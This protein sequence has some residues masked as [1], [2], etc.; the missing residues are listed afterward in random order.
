ML[1]R[2]QR[3]FYGM[4][5]FGSQVLLSFIDL[6]AFWIYIDRFGLN[7][8]FSAIGFSIGKLVIAI[9]GPL[10]G[11]FSDIIWT[12]RW[13]RRKIFFIFGAPGLAIS[14]AL[15]FVPNWFISPGNQLGLLFYMMGAMAIF[16]FFYALLMTPY[17]A[18]M[19]EITEPE[20]RVMVSTY[21][22][23]FWLMG[24]IVGTIGGFAIPMLLS[25]GQDLV[26]IMISWLG[27]I[28][29]FCFIPALFSIK[30]DK[31]DF[32]PQ[33]S[34]SQGF[35]QIF[36]NQNYRFYLV[37]QCAMGIPTTLLGRFV[38]F[39]SEDVLGLIDLQFVII[40]L[41][42]MLATFVFYFLWTWMS[43][44]KR[45][46][47]A[48]LLMSLTVLTFVLPFTLILGQPI[49]ATI[50]TMVQG[51]LFIGMV[52]AGVSGWYLL[53][54]PI[55]AD[56]IEEDE[57]RTS[58]GRAGGYEG[59]INF[60]INIVQII[61]TLLAGF[62]LSLPIIPPNTYSI[63]LLLWGP[64]AALFVAISIFLVRKYVDTDPLQAAK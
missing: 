8:I 54:N 14:C 27:V 31:Q 28:A 30:E 15:S 2:R 61:G 49:L 46:K 32:V 42:L 29:V 36:S 33:P 19:P 64:V 10:I 21:Q 20:E 45:G 58:Q 24:Q 7:P 3:Y 52:A 50:P 34:L 4:G 1:R 56:I 59:F 38:L 40:G 35:Q 37:L 18:W 48:P 11:Y 43:K 60:P 53:P 51:V 26:F 5:R 13:G 47:R 41:L 62:L 55:T 57:S 17:Q 16:N 39:Y 25:I 44:R 63:G 23:G 12:K 6:A 22:N 9:S